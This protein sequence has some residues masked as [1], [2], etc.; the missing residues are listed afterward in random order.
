MK[1]NNKGFSLVELIVVIAIMAILAAVAVVGFSMYIPKAQQ[2]S[3]KQLVSDIEYALDL[4][5]QSNTDNMS[6]GY[7]VLS[8]D[9]APVVGGCGDEA[10]KLI[11]GENWA[12][13]NDLKLAYDKW[14]VDNTF[15]SAAEAT[16]VVNSSYY[17]YK[18]PSQLVDSF[19]SLTDSLSQM[20]ST[21]TGDPLVT[22]QGI[23]MTE[24]EVNS[25]RA[26][27]DSMG[28]KWV[29]G[30]DN[31]AYSTAVSN[32]LVKKTATEMGTSDMDA[33]SGMS[34]LTWKYAMLYGW[35]A[36][37]KDG[38]KCLEDLNAVLT[39][40]NSNS[41]DVVNAVSNAFTTAGENPDFNAYLDVE[42]GD[43]IAD[44]QGLVCIMGTV[45]DWSADADMTTPGLFSSDSIADVVDNYSA[46][47]NVVSGLTQE[48]QQEW[49]A[50]IQN[51]EGIVLFVTKTGQVIS[52]MP[53]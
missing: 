5:Y 45:S 15:P 53:E 43:R 7:I 22:M 25:M 13:R 41:N 34:E 1:N 51:C 52:T 40:K 29:E 14:V 17:Q 39:N 11:Y 28:L 16:A 23:V 21:A 4:Y 3:D 49:D 12:E 30:G 27:L 26:E 46:A 18:T 38:A 35:A 31:T 19:S 10:M 50:L 9:A 48:E 37:S 36:Q 8:P 20:A 42:N 47:V 32:L 33:W 2:A 6:G 44:T 24:S